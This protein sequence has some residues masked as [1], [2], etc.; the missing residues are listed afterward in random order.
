MV[1]RSRIAPVSSKRRKRMAAYARAREQVAERCGGRCEAR[2][3]GVCTGWL[4]HV[5]HRRLRSQG[6]TDDLSNLI[7]CCNSCHRWAHANPR[8]ASRLGLIDFTL[9]E[10]LSSAVRSVTPTAPRSIP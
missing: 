2:V 7:G 10:P 9:A 8:E 1:K 5:H 3:D 4:E 6:G